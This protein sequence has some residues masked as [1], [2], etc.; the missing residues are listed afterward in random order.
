MHEKGEGV[1]HEKTK[2]EGDGTTSSRLQTVSAYTRR[3]SAIG[4]TIILA[5]FWKKQVG[6]LEI[7][8]DLDYSDREAIIARVKPSLF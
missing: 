2:Y 4:Y 5:N 6:T 3:V 1:I 7:G 8:C